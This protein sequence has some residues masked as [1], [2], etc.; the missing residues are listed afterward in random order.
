[1]KRIITAVIVVSMLAAG[2]VM[3]T[4]YAAQE[5]V[6]ESARSERSDKLDRLIFGNSES[7]AAHSLT[8]S[9]T[10]AG[11]DTQASAQTKDRNGLYTG[12]GLGDGLSYRYINPPASKEDK[13]AGFLRFT[14]KADTAAVN[15]VTIRLSGSQYDRGNLI[16]L[17][18]DGSTEYFNPRNGREYAELDCGQYKDNPPLEGRYY[19]ATYKIPQ[20][21]VKSNGTV[22]LKIVSNGKMDSYGTGDYLDITQPSKYIYSI[23]IS[24]NPYY[25]PE[26]SFVGSGVP[27]PKKVEHADGVSAYGF[28]K[29]EVDAMTDR[30][31]SWQCFGDAW[32]VKKTKESAFMDGAVIRNQ[33]V[34]DADM[35]GTSDEI[36]RRYTQEAILH[37]NWSTMS[38][39]M[40]LSNAYCFDF[41][42]Y[43]GNEEILERYFRLLDFYVK[44][45]D[46]EGGWCYH[47]SGADKN[48][49]LGADLNGSGERGTGEWWP[50]MSLGADAMMQSFVQLDDYMLNADEETKSL[51]ERKLEEK[52]DGALT[53]TADKTRREYYIDMFARLRDRLANPKRGVGDF[54]APTNRAG[55][56]NQDFG[57]AYYANHIVGLLTDGAQGGLDT[58]YKREPDDVYLNMVRYKYGEMADGEKWFSDMN[59]TGLEGGASHGGWAGD[60]GTLLISVTER[61]AESARYLPEETGKLFANQAYNAFE[62]A[63]YYY[64][65]AVDAKGN[66]VLSAETFASSRKDGFSVHTSYPIAGYTATKLNSAGALSFLAKYVQDERGY[67]GDIRNTFETKSPHIYTALVD[68]QDILKYYEDVEQLIKENKIEPLP[69]EDAHED[70]AWFDTDAQSVV[71]KNKDDKC[72]VTFNFRRDNWTY[73]DYTRIHMKNSDCDRL[74]D[75]RSSHQ[76]DVYTWKDSTHLTESGNPYTHTRY[77]GMNEVSYGKYIIALNMSKQDAA[78]GQTGKTY[79]MEHT[80]GV[81]KARDLV[82]GKIYEDSNGIKVDVAPQTGVVLE[83]L[84]KVPTET[85]GAVYKAGDLILGSDTKTVENGDTAEFNAAAFEGY[86]LVKNESETKQVTA[87]DGAENKVVF[88]YET[89]TLPKFTA[90]RRVVEDTGWKVFNPTGVEGGIETDENGNI[91]AIC[92]KGIKNEKNLKK[93][94]AYKEI[95]GDF[96]MHFRLNK[97]RNTSSEDDFFGA[98]ITDA[99]DFEK[100]NYVEYRHFSNN[101]NILMVDH[102]DTQEKST[103]SHWAGDMNNKSVPM[104]VIIERRGNMIE[105]WYSLDGENYIQTSKPSFE[106]NGGSA[107]Y[108]GLVMTA[109]TEEMNTAYVSNVE[110]DAEMVGADIKVGDT[111]TLDF[112]VNDADDDEVA[113]TMSQLP[114]GAFMDGH[115]IHF[116]PVRGGEY[117]F[118]AEAN[119]AYHQ[120]PASKTLK[121]NVAPVLKIKVNGEYLNSDV[122]PYLS[123]SSRTMIPARALAEALGAEVSAAEDMSKVTISKDG[124]VM[125]FNVGSETAELDG[126]EKKLD[127]PAV[128]ADSRLMVPLRFITE[129][130]GAEV[131]WIS[132]EYTVEIIK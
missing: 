132:D 30:V 77:D 97:I 53:G 81:T 66:R 62:A 105:Y 5:N 52:I 49:W 2:T 76:G 21:L 45:Q 70:F 123:D 124:H 126:A 60:Y 38:N 35:S 88:E 131:N 82:S 109:A 24:T 1:M 87:A 48:A 63:K 107:L 59:G 74:A 84:E 118:T 16:L 103:T 13:T 47:T 18:G 36:A 50:L 65:P 11:T 83:I 9:R 17:A 127:A 73:N 108:V 90:A 68:S 7:E 56:A 8:E 129:S 44:A 58:D 121:V 100:A 92:S 39:L 128:I 4:A 27:E 110:I 95:T 51:Y 3:P 101:N 71:F 94:F 93:T 64:Y 26:D 57:F 14:L 19:Y 42:K 117:V 89:N 75:V 31:L 102:I 113:F 115:L 119:D 20:Q 114:E 130:F 25:V 112:S 69:M 67:T 15:Y 54:Y 41:S 79:T 29:G 80:T 116:T 55:T 46:S 34:A 12:G 111:V 85:V 28:L 125:V 122:S 43:K 96:R 22:D 33:P 72:Y 104:D 98:F 37:Q 91:T 40:I 61:Y 99:L 6:K 86:S 32:E 106:Y 120:L 78:V 10:S 23:D